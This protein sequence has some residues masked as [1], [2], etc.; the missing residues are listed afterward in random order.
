MV[1]I[2][3]DGKRNPESILFSE[4]SKSNDRTNLHILINRIIKLSILYLKEKDEQILDYLV[5]QINIWFLDKQTMMNPNLNFSQFKRGIRINSTL[6]HSGIIE[7]KDIYQLLILLKTIEFDISKNKNINY[8]N[9]CNWFRDYQKWLI[10]SPQ[11]KIESTMLNNHGTC[12]LLQKAALE[13]FFNQEVD[14]FKS[15]LY[16]SM[17]IF[18][19][20][21]DEGVQTFEVKRSLPVHYCCFNLQQFLNINS[22]LLYSSNYNLFGKNQEENRLSKAVMWI[23]KNLYQKIKVNESDTFDSRRIDVLLH[24]AR[25]QSRFIRHNIPKMLYEN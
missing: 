4:E 18:N 8:G 6:N 11:G 15:Y 7:F 2:L 14:L 24:I 22:I 12:Y 17:L 23:Y 3:R 13:S 5:E 16:T 1:S 20:I 10:G 19:S 25:S 21:S 9:F